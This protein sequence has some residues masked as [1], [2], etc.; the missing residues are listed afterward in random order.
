MCIAVYKPAGAKFPSKKKIQTMFRS[1]PDGA[2]FMYADGKKVYIQKGFMT[3]SDFNKALNKVKHRTDLPFALHFR[4]TTHGATS[5]G[6]CHPFP[7]SEDITELTATKLT[8]EVGVVH[9]G[10]ISMCNYA[11]KISDTAEFIRRY[12]VKLCANGI[13]ADILTCIDKLIGSKMVVLEA[14]K[15][16]HLIGDFVQDGNGVY[17]SNESYKPISK[18]KSKSYFSINP[19]QYEYDFYKDCNGICEYCKHEKDCFGYYSYC[20]PYLP[21][22]YNAMQD[23]SNVMTGGGNAYSNNSISDIYL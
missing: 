15:N 19:Y 4:I 23:L 13:N 3:L 17:Y 1:N 18:Q 20:N 16:A 22:N 7:L 5:G 21:S 14:D 10:I 11:D 8:A 6:L 12:M 9:N 2:G